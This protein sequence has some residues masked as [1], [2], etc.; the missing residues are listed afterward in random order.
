GQLWSSCRT[1]PILWCPSVQFYGGGLVARLRERWRTLGSS[2]LGRSSQD[3]DKAGPSPVVPA[4]SFGLL[5][6]SGVS[7]PV[8]TVPVGIRR[9]GCSGAW[10]RASPANWRRDSEPGIDRLGGTGGRPGGAGRGG[11]Q[12][13]HSGRAGGA[14]VGVEGV[15]ILRLDRRR[16]QGHCERQEL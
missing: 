14:A 3:C 13:G 12:V 2:N 7:R 8:A 11:G 16:H 10:S 5:W 4:V 1:S 6:S 15:A 9:G